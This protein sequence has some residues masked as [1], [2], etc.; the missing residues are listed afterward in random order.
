MISQSVGAP[1]I[2][3]GKITYALEDAEKVNL[4]TDVPTVDNASYTGTGFTGSKNIVLPEQVQIPRK[5]IT[6]DLLGIY[7]SSTGAEISLYSYDLKL[8]EWILIK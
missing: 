4:C 5:F 3:Y 2:V 6:G 1:D 7:D 8:R